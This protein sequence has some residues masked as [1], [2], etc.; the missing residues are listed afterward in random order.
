[1][2]TNLSH[3][4]EPFFHEAVRSSYDQL[5]LHD[6]EMTGYVARMLCEFTEA[7]NFYSLRDENEQPIEDL[8]GMLHASDPVY[9]T[10]PSF[11]AERTRRR[12]IGDYALFVAGMYPEALTAGRKAR[13]SHTSMSELITAGKESYRIVSLF[14]LFEYVDEAPLF[15]RLAENFERCVLGLALVREGLS[16]RIALKLPPPHK[17]S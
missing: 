11:D 5:G 9:G 13:R 1:M 16:P 2:P 12:Y 3:P 7:D 6:L 14:D 4:L 17:R 8:A 15:A 10:A